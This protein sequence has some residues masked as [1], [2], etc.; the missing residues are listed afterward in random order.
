MTGVGLWLGLSPVFDDWL[1]LRVANLTDICTNFIKYATFA[2]LWGENFIIITV[3]TGNIL[4][5]KIKWSTLRSVLGDRSG[6]PWN[7]AVS[8]YAVLQYEAHKSTFY[9]KDFVRKWTD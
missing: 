2:Y 3:F 9:S 1:N 8:L 5:I 6:E 7:I 4:I